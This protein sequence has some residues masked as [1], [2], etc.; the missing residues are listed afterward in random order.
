MY[1]RPNTSL[2]RKTYF[3]KALYDLYY[4]L[5][6]SSQTYALDHFFSKEL[7]VNRTLL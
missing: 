7:I 6:Q 1:F 3:Y 5:L 2:A 4:W